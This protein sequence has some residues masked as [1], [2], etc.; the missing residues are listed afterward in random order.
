YGQLALDELLVGEITKNR[1]FWGNKYGVQ[2]GAKYINAFGVSNLDLQLEHNLAR[3]FT[4]S[5][6]DSVAN[7]THYNQP[8]AHP[9]G[10]N[11]SEIIGIARYQPAPKWLVQAKAIY[12][13]QGRD[14]NAVSYGSNIFLPHIPPYR[15]EE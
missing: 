10:A 14:S 7:Y 15:T 6:R 2:L 1:G 5:H 13:T 3:P 12:Y 4:Y 9:L 8:L 11:F